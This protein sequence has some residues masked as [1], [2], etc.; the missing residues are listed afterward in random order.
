[1]KR[2]LPDINGKGFSEWSDM[3]LKTITRGGSKPELVQ[4]GFHPSGPLSFIAFLW[5]LNHKDRLQ[6][7]DVVEVQIKVNETEWFSSEEKWMEWSGAQLHK[8]IG[9]IKER[10]KWT[11]E[12]SSARRWRSW[13]SDYVGR[14][15]PPITCLGLSCTVTMQLNVNFHSNNIDLPD[16]IKLRMVF[17]IFW[18]TR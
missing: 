7:Y 2:T 6:L 5:K 15:R 14:V 11:K 13:A 1:M 16:S 4:Q 12:E 17:T 9:K 18:W 10:G 3:K 8:G